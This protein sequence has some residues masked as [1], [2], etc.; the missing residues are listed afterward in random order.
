MSALDYNLNHPFAENL[1]AW[2]TDAVAGMKVHDKIRREI[3]KA[4][5]KLAHPPLMYSNE[6]RRAFSNRMYSNIQY[7]NNILNKAHYN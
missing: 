5:F 4:E 7:W 3:A 2:N 6:Q 1:S